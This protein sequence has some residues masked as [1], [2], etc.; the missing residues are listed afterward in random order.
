MIEKSR[1]PSGVLRLREIEAEPAINCRS[2]AAITGI[3]PGQVVRI[4]TTEL[5]GDNRLTA[6]Y[7][8]PDGR[9]LERMLFRSGEANLLVGLGP[10]MHWAKILSWPAKPTG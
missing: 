9:L 5:V 10:S 3:E 8:A 2:N 6:Y 1:S 4:V 7:K